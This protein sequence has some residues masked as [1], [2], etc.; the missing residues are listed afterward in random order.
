VIVIEAAGNGAQDLD[1]SLYQKGGTGFPQA[2]RNSFRR[3]NRDSRA[4][5][6]GAGAPPPK[7]HGKDHGPD[8]SR[9]DFSNYGSAV[10]VQGWG[11]EVTTCGY[12][13]LQGGINEDHW[14]TDQFS[15]TSSASPIVVGTLGCVQGVRHKRGAILLTPTTAR[16]LLRSTGS[17]Q[18]DAPGRPKMQRIGNRPDLR[19]LLAA[20][21]VASR[22]GYHGG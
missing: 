10:D 2:W 3:S 6:V 14:Y 18:Q 8:R 17:P 22:G 12:G 19:Q 4:I 5:L 9:L 7:T 20:P 15:G 11:R 16:A 13:D 1:D 21:A